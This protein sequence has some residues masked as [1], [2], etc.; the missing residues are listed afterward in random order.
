MKRMVTC[1]FLGWLLALVGCF[2]SAPPAQVVAP[3]PIAV[4]EPAGPPPLTR[5]QVNP[6]NARQKAHE[7]DEEIAR[8]QKRLLLKSP[9]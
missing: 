4:E 5:D 9:Y 2:T 1:A 7:M 8:A 3:E 6:S